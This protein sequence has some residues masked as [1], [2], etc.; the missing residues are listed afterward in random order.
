MRSRVA[1][2]FVWIA[3]AVSL[4]AWHP[5]VHGGIPD[6]EVLQQQ[7]LS[8]L[9]FALEDI[10]DGDGLGHAHP[11]CSCCFPIAAHAGLSL[12]PL[13]ISATGIA[14][15]TRSKEISPNG[16]DRLATAP[17]RGPPATSLHV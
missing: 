10:C 2:F 14:H 16:N 9:G 3:V 4:T 5:L 6:D 7:N 12:A 13:P 1:S 8:L 11:N 17:I 15:W